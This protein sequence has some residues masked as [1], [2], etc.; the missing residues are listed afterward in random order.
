MRMVHGLYDRSDWPDEDR[1][2]GDEPDKAQWTDPD[3]GMACLAVRNK[4]GAWCGYVGVP[5]GHP[6]HGKNYDQCLHGEV[7]PDR[8]D[9]AKGY[10]GKTIE[11]RLDVHGGITFANG[12]AEGPDEPDHPR[13]CHV[14]EPGQTGDVWWLGFDCVHAWDYAPGMHTK[15]YA[16]MAAVRF[17]E[18]P[19]YEEVTMK[20]HYW[21]LDELQEECASLAE[22]LAEYT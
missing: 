12:C 20:D 18:A 13:I 10:C 1:G 16:R 7:C 22:Q 6:F 8:E 9:E 21:T 15:S 5:P 19:D 2:W 17:P 11:G 3:T 14:P 4:L